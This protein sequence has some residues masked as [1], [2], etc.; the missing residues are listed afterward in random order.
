MT[1]STQSTPSLALG[2]STPNSATNSPTT[3]PKSS[4][5][6]NVNPDK[7]IAA[8]ISNRRRDHLIG[9]LEALIIEEV[10]EASK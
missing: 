1:R 2:E 6:L 9:F 8:P 10:T 4:L 7:P 3:A 5:N